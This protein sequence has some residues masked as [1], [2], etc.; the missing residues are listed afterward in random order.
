MKKNRYKNGIKVGMI[1]IVI[2]LLLST[3]KIILS[4]YIN[5]VSLLADAVN[6]FNDMTSSILTVL[7]FKLSNKKPNKKHPYG[8]AR[9]E[10]I[11]SF[12]ISI[13]MTIM[14][15]LF[16]IESISKII[17]PE[18]LEINKITYFILFIT[19]IIKTLQYFYYKKMSK[20]LKSL[21]LDATTLETRN[22]IITNI[23]ILISILFIQKTNYNIDG[24]IALI[25]SFILIKSS[26]QMLKES[27]YELIGKAPSDEMLRK[28][29]NKLL[30]NKEIKKINRIII[31]NYGENINYINVHIKIDKKEKIN[32][33]IKLIKK[34]EKEFDNNITIQ[35]DF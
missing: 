18:K 13:F 9:Y 14:S 22:D 2:N 21:T 35:I 31:H 20:K 30:K 26:V 34:L 6:N 16:I 19:L 17:K 15:I 23:S 4:Y 5:S 3:T 24:Y 8:Y 1:G 27:I 10:Y 29:K 33:I 11:S 28:I 32:N 25:V 7:G 12:L